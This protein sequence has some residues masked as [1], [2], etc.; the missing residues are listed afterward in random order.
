MDPK[1]TFKLYRSETESKCIHVRNKAT[2]VP[3]DLE[4]LN[5][6]QLFRYILDI[7]SSKDPQSHES[8]LYGI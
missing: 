1:G 8:K 7:I 6:L 2:D 3:C 4:I 5:A